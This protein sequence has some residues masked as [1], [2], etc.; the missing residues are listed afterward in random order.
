MLPIL[1]SIAG[2]FMI[3]DIPGVSIYSSTKFSVTAL[4]EYL[5]SFM[6]LENL[7][8]RVTVTCIHFD[9][10]IDL[11]IILKCHFVFKFQI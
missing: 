6:S 9:T 10:F 11:I 8:I 2:H 5:R 7:P 3:N 1:F 4:T